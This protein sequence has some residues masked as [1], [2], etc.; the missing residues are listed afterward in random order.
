MNEGVNVLDRVGSISDTSKTKSKRIL[1][2]IIKRTFD[3]VFSLIGLI[4]LIPVAILVK[5]MYVFTGDFNSIFFTQKRIGKNGKEFNF[6]KFRSMVPNADKELEKLLLNDPKR[7]KEYKINKKLKDDPRITL[8]GK[9]LR[10]SSLDELPQLINI[11]HG[12]MSFVGNRPYLP[13][14]KEDMGDHFDKIVATKPG[15]TGYWQVNGRSNT[16]FEHRLKLEEYYSEH[17]G[18]KLDIKIFFKTFA[19]VLLRKGAD[20]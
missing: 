14:E 18:L 15:L 10:K 4:F 1:Y 16:S 17:C 2:R 11:F 3:I 6:Y 8:A 7:R 20:K 12:D 9:F 19:V 13:K 5:L